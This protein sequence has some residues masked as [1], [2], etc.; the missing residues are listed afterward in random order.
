MKIRIL[1]ADSPSYWYAKAI[2]SIVE[3]K[4]ITYPQGEAIISKKERR[5]FNKF[6]P[7][8]P[9][10]IISIV[11]PG[12]FELV[13]EVFIPKEKFDYIK[14]VTPDIP[15]NLVNNEKPFEVVSSVEKESYNLVIDGKVNFD[16]FL[17]V[18]KCLSTVCFEEAKEDLKK[19]NEEIIKKMFNDVDNFFEKDKFKFSEKEAP[20]KRV[21]IEP[22]SNTIYFKNEKD[23]TILTISDDK[24]PVNTFHTIDNVTNTSKLTRIRL[25]ANIS[26]D[27]WYKKLAGMELD[28]INIDDMLGAF[29][30][31]PKLQGIPVS[32][33]YISINDF[34]IV[35]EDSPS[36]SIYPKKFTEMYLNDKLLNKTSDNQHRLV[37]DEI[38]N[39]YAE[40]KKFKVFDFEL[41]VDKA[42]NR[43]VL[44]DYFAYNV[45]KSDRF[46]TSSFEA[47]LD[48]LTKPELKAI[49]AFENAKNF[50]K[51]TYFDTE[52]L[53]K[54]TWT[55]I[56]MDHSE[57]DYKEL[58]ENLKKLSFERSRFNPGIPYPGGYIKT[59]LID[60]D[61]IKKTI[62]D[63]PIVKNNQAYNKLRTHY[64]S[65]VLNPKEIFIWK[66]FNKWCASLSAL[67]RNEIIGLKY[68]EEYK[69]FK[70]SDVPVHRIN[71][72]DAMEENL[73][74]LYKFF[75]DMPVL[76]FRGEWEMNKAYQKDQFV[77]FDGKYYH[78]FKNCNRMVSV[79]NISFWKPMKGNYQVKF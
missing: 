57:S 49:L 77:I 47:W 59:S 61:E 3:A 79:L 24:L 31:I 28:S 46:V 19:T 22:G 73:Q 50:S 65:N 18:K 14:G 11:A 51:E 45:I 15:Y 2:N 63:G 43:A 66:N 74:K 8:G 10:P 34:N 76:N 72:L 6:N 30:L 4:S 35:N 42:A 60:V 58:T 75:E 32:R 20:K 69:D 40:N 39:V 7:V 13:K 48:K 21:V 68:S 64:E 41:D 70:K 26:P 1:R 16:Y 33:G 55:P 5:K 17:P 54:M 53:K 44:Q 38:K 27:K 52:E 78:C 71:I 23:E 62:S 37:M 56:K 67:Q 9:P 12:D 25:H 36:N 29:V